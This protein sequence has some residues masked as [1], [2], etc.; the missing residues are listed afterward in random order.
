MGERS[1]SPSPWSAAISVTSSGGRTSSTVSATMLLPIPGP[2]GAAPP[3][4][5]TPPREYEDLVAQCA[6]L[7]DRWPGRYRG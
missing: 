5:T 6:R 3:V 4:P 1:G 2:H 7:G